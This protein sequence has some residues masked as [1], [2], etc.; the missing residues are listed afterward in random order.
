MIAEYMEPTPA[1]TS[2]SIR[3]TV[4]HAQEEVEA[5]DTGQGLSMSGSSSCSYPNHNRDSCKKN[6]HVQ[7]KICEQLWMISWLASLCRSPS[8]RLW[9]AA[10][11]GTPEGGPKCLGLK[12]DQI[13]L[14]P[15]QP[16]QADQMLTLLTQ[17][18]SS[19]LS[20]C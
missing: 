1:S 8:S 12:H 10:S 17:E 3:I 5:S 16:H 15:F 14:H 4:H 18:G 19:F 7:V 20:T 9:D 13:T 6:V 11:N 2:A